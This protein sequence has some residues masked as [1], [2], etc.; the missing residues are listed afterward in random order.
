[1][2]IT[3]LGVAGDL[4]FGVYLVIDE[5]ADKTE[6]MK[7]AV[8]KCFPGINIPREFLG[9]FPKYLNSKVIWRFFVLN[10]IRQYY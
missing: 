1:M 2:R 9:I 5:L 4:L 6:I 3:C 8:G 7:L 10:K